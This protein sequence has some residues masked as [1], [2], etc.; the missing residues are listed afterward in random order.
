M[1]KVAF[2]FFA[3]FCLA[4]WM[5]QARGVLLTPA[6]VIASHVDG[7]AVDIR[8]NQLIQGCGAECGV[9]TF[10]NTVE[11]KSSQGTYAHAYRV[12]ASDEYV[13]HSAGLLL[14]VATFAGGAGFPTVAEVETYFSEIDPSFAIHDQRISP[15]SNL[16]VPAA[17]LLKVVQASL[18]IA[19][20]GGCLTRF[21]T[22][23][24][25]GLLYAP[26]ACLDACQAP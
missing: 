4:A 9:F 20:G 26:D 7:V 8:Q 16:G 5:G 3:V 6:L 14:G 15:I 19:A 2:V 1:K 24:F 21:E 17:Q 23:L 12:T 18:G 10:Q 25:A 13:A 11:I 22:D